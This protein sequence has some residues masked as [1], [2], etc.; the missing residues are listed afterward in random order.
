MTKSASEIAEEMRA[1]ASDHVKSREVLT[2]LFTES[3]ELQHVP[4]RPSDG[5]IAGRVLAEIVRRES[6]AVFRALPDIIYDDPEITVEAD[7]IRVRRRTFG[8]LLDGTTI[9]VRTNTLFRIADGAIVA[10]QSDMDPEGVEAWQKVLAVGGFEAP[11]SIDG[12]S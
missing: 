2:C 4:R 11:R 6:E 9:D 1:V 3:V 8:T 10:L 12:G 5:A 7:A